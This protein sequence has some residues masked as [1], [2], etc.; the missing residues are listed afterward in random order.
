MGPNCANSTPSITLIKT[1]LVWGAE[2]PHSCH[3]RQSHNRAMKKKKWLS[4]QFWVVV[5]MERVSGRG[6]RPGCSWGGE[7]WKSLL[8]QA[9][10]GNRKTF[11]FSLWLPPPFPPLL[12]PPGRNTCILTGRGHDHQTHGYH[13]LIETSERRG[14]GGGNSTNTIAQPNPRKSFFSLLPPLSVRIQLHF[15]GHHK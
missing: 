1:C 3:S 8:C 2:W 5:V 11:S 4:M 9:T 15:A 10:V 12:C 7:P 14:G 6:L 13:K